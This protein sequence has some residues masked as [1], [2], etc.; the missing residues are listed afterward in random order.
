MG[1]Y[2]YNILKEKYP[3]TFH[4]IVPHHVADEMWNRKNNN[5]DFR[6]KLNI[7]EKD[8]VI[9]S[10]GAFRNQDEVNLF[11]NMAKDVG[12]KG[13]TY[14]AP[15]IPIGKLYNGRRLI[16]SISFIK[17]Y[18]KYK[19]LGVRFAGFLS[20]EELDEWL[21]A[22]D[23]VF[24]QR[25]EILNSGNVPLAFSAQKVVV[26]P[27]LGNVGEILKETHNYTFNPDNREMVCKEVKKAIDAYRKDS[28][29]GN[30]NYEYAKKNWNTSKICNSIIS[31]LSLLLER[32]NKQSQ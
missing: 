27:N 15:R 3:N 1:T 9:S 11:L 7:P 25:K 24:I 28:N 29:L 32:T 30:T 22:S 19:L 18:I 16:K 5:S 4:F 26:G 6:R 10:F 12:R 13:I 8:I 2:S 21:C 14:L 31:T 17:K 23:I 20:S